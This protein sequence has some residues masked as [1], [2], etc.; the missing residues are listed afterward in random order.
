MRPPPAP[1]PRRRRAAGAVVLALAAGFYL[2]RDVWVAWTG[3]L[4]REGDFR[5]YFAAARALLGG[6]TPYRVVA[7]DYPPLVAFLLL[8]VAGLGYS[9]ARAV[10]F[11]AAEGALL[12]SAWLLWRLLGGGLAAAVVV[13][14]V[15]AGGGTVAENLVLGQVSPLLLLLLL[16]ALGG[17][18]RGRSP[19]GGAAA[20][21]VGGGL[22]LGAA[23]ALKLWPAVLFGAFAL[24]GKRR[25]LA[26]GVLALLVLVA[27]PWA[28][29]ATRPPPHLPQSADYW[30]GTP[31]LHNFS[32]PAVA[33]RL[34]D[35]PAAGAPL[36]RDWLRGNNPA[37]L[38]LPPAR[39]ALGVAVAAV[40]LLA[41]AAVLW[42]R[43]RRRPLAGEEAALAAA[44]LVTLA[45]L[46]SPIS[47]Y[48]YQLLAFPGL[49]LLAWRW[50][51]R[52]GALVAL[53]LVGGGLTWSHVAA[54]GLYLARYGPTAAN[55]PL[56]WLA[57][58]LVPALGLVLFA[59]LVGELG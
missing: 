26:A 32:L 3:M 37:Q 44:A 12:A 47:W 50:R 18:A 57:T 8:P 14:V 1:S 23:A 51:R 24:A 21:A 41:G 35:P 17:L 19:A 36:P 2:Y 11:V 59:F 30:M 29:V 33:L 39:R 45:L 54:V 49:A 38:H 10:W 52:A 42:W 58:S 13:A 6:G 4:A 7:F 48:H 53:A 34:A 56:L 43:L 25:G 5:N 27:V 9:A 40:T 15:W 55:P 31:A 46:A 22:A 28:V 16:L 20:G